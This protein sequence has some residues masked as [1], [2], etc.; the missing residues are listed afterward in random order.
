MPS[1]ACPGTLSSLFE[2]TF[3]DFELIV[4]DD[5]SSD[6]SADI[7]A[8]LRGP[9]AQGSHQPGQYRPHP[10]TEPCDRLQPGCAAGKA[11]CR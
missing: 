10:I 7:L 5:A 2:Q 6:A 11:G 9:A 4:V 3:Q 8:R 1:G